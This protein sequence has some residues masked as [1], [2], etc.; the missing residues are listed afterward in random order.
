VWCCHRPP[1]RVACAYSPLPW[2][3]VFKVVPRAPPAPPF[4][5]GGAFPSARRRGVPPLLHANFNRIRE[6]YYDARVRGGGAGGD[7]NLVGDAGVSSSGTSIMPPI[8]L[9]DRLAPSA[10][11]GGELSRLALPQMFLLPPGAAQH[12][13]ALESIAWSSPAHRRSCRPADSPSAS[14]DSRPRLARPT[15]NRSAAGPLAAAERDSEGISLCSGKM[16]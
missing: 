12:R 14:S 9:A 10:A 16:L 4:G 15:R 3:K 1:N 13:P 5:C 11:R 7:P 6:I 8:L 2:L